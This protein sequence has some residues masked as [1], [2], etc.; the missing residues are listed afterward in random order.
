LVAHNKDRTPNKE[1]LVALRPDEGRAISLRTFKTD[2][3][4]AEGIAGEIAAADAKTWGKTAILART[5]ATL[6]PFLEALRTRGVKAAIATRRDGFVSPQFAWLYACLDQTLRPADRR[7]FIVLANAANRI[8]GTDLD[9]ALLAAEADAAGKS[10]LE[11]WGLVAQTTENPVAKTLA[12]F[13]LKLV[14]SR[15]NWKAVLSEALTFLPQTAQSAEGVVSDA[16][17]DK[18]AWEAAVKAIRAEKGSNLE[19]AEL[20]QGI[21]LRPKE[22]PPDP[23]AVRLFTVHAA[24]GLEFDHVW[25]VGL[26]ESVFPSWQSLRADAQ[27]ADLEEERR[28]C[29]VAITRTQQTLVLSRAESY[30]GRTKQPSRFIAEMG[31]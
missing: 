14:Q 18:A 10:Y 19:L 20:L 26:A 1:L 11:Q 24:K 27:P 8:A 25:V 9:P 13:A 12:Q 30:Q 31:L 15:N 29:F 2:K 17:E 21:A 28:N 7:I 5:R 6:V 23:N 3:E 4:E 16:S 22:P